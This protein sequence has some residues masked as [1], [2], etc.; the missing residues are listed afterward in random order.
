MTDAARRAYDEV[1]AFDSRNPEILEQ[2]LRVEKIERLRAERAEA[3]RRTITPG[4]EEDDVHPEQG[5]D[6]SRRTPMDEDRRG[7]ERRGRRSLRGSAE[8]NS[9]SSSHQ[10]SKGKGSQ[11]GR[12]SIME[13][14]VK[15]RPPEP[16]R[17]RPAA[18][19]DMMVC[20]DGDETDE[21]P[22]VSVMP[23]CFEE[24][25]G[26]ERWWNPMRIVARQLLS[27][28]SHC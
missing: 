16:A 19:L 12:P 1:D 28:R 13:Q 3:R 25:G 4:D 17:R 9:G 21:E 23:R 15:S 24:T 18:R 11:R 14:T 27:L 20:E 5:G 2:C 6:A 10:S 8:G 22:D 26:C 7:S